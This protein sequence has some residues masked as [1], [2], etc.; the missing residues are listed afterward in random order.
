MSAL[1]NSLVPT[2][3]N[4]VNFSR[5][6]PYAFKPNAARYVGLAVTVAFLR[7]HAQKKTSK[8][9]NEG[10]V[11]AARLNKETEEA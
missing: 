1:W 5:D 11:D 3:N 10:T 7:F 9:T 4:G 6:K 2:G 8:L